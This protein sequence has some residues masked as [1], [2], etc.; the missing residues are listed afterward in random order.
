MADLIQQG[1]SEHLSKTASEDLV[2]MPPLQLLHR[3]GLVGQIE[4]FGSEVVF[5]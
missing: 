2:F 4:A 5:N 3:I 1:G